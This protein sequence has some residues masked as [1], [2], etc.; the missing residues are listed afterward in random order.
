MKPKEGIVSKIEACV[1]D[2]IA[3][4]RMECAAL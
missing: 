3:L 4:S 1:E 2:L